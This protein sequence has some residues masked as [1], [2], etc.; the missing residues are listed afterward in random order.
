M[1]MNTKKRAV[2]VGFV[3]L[4]LVCAILIGYGMGNMRAKIAIQ[5]FSKQIESMDFNNLTLTIY[6]MDPHL[7]TL[8]P[9]DVNTLIDVCGEQKIVVNGSIL[10][11][12]IDLL[13][14]VKNAKLKPVSHKIYMDARI[15]YIFEAN[16]KGKILDVVMWGAHEDVDEEAIFVNG[17]SVECE[18]VFFDVIMPF[19]PEY[20]ANELAT[21]IEWYKNNNT[22]IEVGK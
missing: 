9:L 7:L 17:V 3:L 5:N 22:V 19:L 15:Y 12:H 18:E 20:I 1:R 4:L 10:E 8:Y 13:R 2:L 14:Q 6:Y 16:G 21:Y 11:E